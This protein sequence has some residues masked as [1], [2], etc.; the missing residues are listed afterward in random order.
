M[1]TDVGRTE[2]ARIKS[3]DRHDLPSIPRKLFSFPFFIHILAFSTDTQPTTRTT[4]TLILGKYTTHGL[5]NGPPS[6]QEDKQD[7]EGRDSVS[8][9]VTDFFW[10]SLVGVWCIRLSS[11]KHTCPTLDWYHF[12]FGILASSLLRSAFGLASVE[13]PNTKPQYTPLDT[14]VQ[15]FIKCLVQERPLGTSVSATH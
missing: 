4:A 7:R 5:S 9:F 1:L 11:C 10:L 6:R 3:N 15:R 14:H 8:G 2:W 12:S 13:Y